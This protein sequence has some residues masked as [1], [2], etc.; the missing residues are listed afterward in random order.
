MYYALSSDSFVNVTVNDGVFNVRI[1]GNGSCYQEHVDLSAESWLNLSTKIAE[2]DLTV[3]SLQHGGRI[4]VQIPI[5][6]KV[7][8]T[9]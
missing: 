7:H 3:E 5:G 1:E 2:I 4:D 8:V 9:L 6:R